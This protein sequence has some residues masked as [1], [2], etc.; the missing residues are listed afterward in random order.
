MS[1]D[2]INDTTKN[3][4]DNSKEQTNNKIVGSKLGTVKWF[5]HSRGYG[6]I[7]C[8]DL[9]ET[10]RDYFVHH[11]SILTKSNVYKM[12]QKGEYIH[13]NEKVENNKYYAVDVTGINGGILLCE[14]PKHNNRKS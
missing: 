1:K 2:T 14:V 3:G 6:F 12:L 13:F 10:E 5:N 9:N 4:S 8:I 11:S 7:T